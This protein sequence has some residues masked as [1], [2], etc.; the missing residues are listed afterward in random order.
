MTLKLLALSSLALL[1]NAH[2]AAYHKAMYC[3]NGTVAGQVNYNNDDPV[4]PLWMLQK[5]DYW[6]HHFNGCDEFPPAPGDFLELPAGSSFTVEV[7]ANRGVTSLS[8]NGQFATEWGDG[9]NHPDDY[10]I[11]NLA[12]SP[13]SESDCIGSP[14]MH[15]QNQSMAAG[16]AFA[17]S[18][19]SELSEV[20]IDNLVVFT[21]RYNTPWKRITSY[22]V[23][24][25]MPACPADGCTCAWVWIPDGCGEPNIYMQGFK[26]MVTGATST[27]P[28]ATPKPPVWCEGDQ[29]TCTQGAKQILIWNQAEGNNIAVTGNDLSGNAKSPAYNSKCGFQDGA[30]NDIFG[31]SSSAAAPPVAIASSPLSAT[32]VSSS[33]SASSSSAVASSSPAVSSYPSPSSS[34]ASSP[35]LSS[36]ISSSAVASS[37]VSS[38]PSPSSSPASSSKISS[39]AAASSAVSSYPS[40]SSPAS[41]STISSSAA[42]SAASPPSCETSTS[43]MFI[44][45]TV[46]PPAVATTSTPSYLATSQSANNLVATA[47][48]SSLSATPT[49]HKTCRKRMVHKPVRRRFL[50]K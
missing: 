23:P 45:S 21:V 47:V 38:Y 2:M 43:T 1:T 3:F 7:A 11:A 50:F 49:G 6:F 30:Q 5:N 8:F 25:D 18:Y 26:C 32:S 37:A 39:S 35:A 19:Q 28:L 4:S 16:T 33:A 31:T 24:K 41:S 20:T 12:G 29:S 14:N 48:S 42:A 9:K 22:D 10:S 27:T 34:P 15:T 17:I 36:K 46:Q 40:P 44:T 13:L